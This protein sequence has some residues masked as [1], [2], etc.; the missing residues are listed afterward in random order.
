[1]F[2][3]DYSDDILIYGNEKNDE[4][5]RLEIK[6]VPC[7]Y[8]HTQWGYTGDSIHSECEHDLDQQIQYLGPLDFMIYHT[9]EIMM[10]QQYGDATIQRQSTLHNVQVDESKPNWI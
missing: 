5:Q 3:L 7:N 10:P 2:C 4:Y 8:L 6:L 9:E 1:M